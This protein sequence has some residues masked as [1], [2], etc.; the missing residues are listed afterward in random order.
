MEG[1]RGKRRRRNH[2]NYLSSYEDDSYGDVVATP[3]RPSL[4][5]YYSLLSLL[6][7]VLPSLPPS[8]GHT[9]EKEEAEEDSECGRG[10]EEETA[11]V[12]G[13]STLSSFSSFSGGNAHFCAKRERERE[14]EEVSFPLAPSLFFLLL[15]F[16]FS[17]FQEERSPAHPTGG[18]PRRKERKIFPSTDVSP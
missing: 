5:L 1:G 3:A 2:I 12:A 15:L 17:G 13:V 14:R 10:R 11:A 4:P 9:G 16:A 6:W 8:D 18:R 7:H